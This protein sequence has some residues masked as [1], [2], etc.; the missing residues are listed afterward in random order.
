MD[1]RNKNLFRNKS[2]AKNSKPNL[3]TK[4][5]QKGRTFHS[6]KKNYVQNGTRQQIV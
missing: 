4:V 6:K 3:E 5:G 2:D 1:A